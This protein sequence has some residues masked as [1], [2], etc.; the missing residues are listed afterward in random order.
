VKVTTEALERCETLLTVEIEPKQ[1]QK[2][3][4]QAA[5]RIAREVRIPGFR[6]GKAPYNVVV[7]RFGLDVV[8]QEAAEQSLDKLIQD[9]LT[10]A[11]LTPFA[12]IS[13][14]NI[15]WDPL[16]IVVKVP[17][18][19]QVELANYREIRLD[20]E[21]V[22]IADQDV[23][24]ELE[25]IQE[26]NATWVPVERP[27]QIGDMVDMYLL[28]KD[29]DEVISEKESLE[30]ELEDPAEHEGHD[31]PDLTTPIIGLSAGEEKTFTLTYPDDYD[32]E[33]YAGKEI[34][35]QA[36]VNTVKEKDLE[37]IDDEFAQSFSDFDTLEEF[38]A[39]IRTNLQESRER[40]QDRELGNKAVEQLIE[41]ATIEWPQAFEDE[42]IQRELQQFEREVGRLGLN[43]ESYYQIQKTTKDEFTEE[44]RGRV[45]DQL[46]R[47]L[48]LGKI[49]ELEKLSV[50]ES[51]VLGRAKL[52]A[53]MY[54]GGE[55]IWRNILA[56][57]S[58][59]A[60]IADEL[61]AD[62]AISRLAAIARGENPSIGDENEGSEEADE[63]AADSEPAVE[64][65]DE[66]PAA[67]VVSE[68]SETEAAEQEAQ[69]EV[70]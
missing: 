9:A 34:T 39:D 33:T 17:T 26:Q 15:D 67:E 2:L 64:E 66:A 6:P 13:L 25:K 51:E 20:Y 5:K 18:E 56:S 35:F 21:S 14:D 45:I 38:K 12:Q 47:S 49:V 70:K 69:S 1:E 65:G 61:L 41:Q 32:N 31:H 22:E 11:D 24:Q 60:M 55:Q 54:G 10:E 52:I 16:T 3:L 46:K 62:K 59:Q 63:D 7:R 68:P 27:A 44:I 53:D 30:F 43:M 37:P 40:E 19:P 36:K 48:I 4:Q 42:S 23:Q 8:Q 29:G 50:G 28:E 57:Q 58:Q